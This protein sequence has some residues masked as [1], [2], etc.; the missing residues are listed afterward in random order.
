MEIVGGKTDWRVIFFWERKIFSFFLN[1][2][3]DTYTLCKIE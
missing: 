1:L 3:I 2:E